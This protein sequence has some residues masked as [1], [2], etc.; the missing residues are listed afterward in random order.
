[1]YIV[2]VITLIISAIVF[3]IKEQKCPEICHLIYTPVC[4]GQTYSNNCSLQVDAC[5]TGQDIKFVDDEP[6]SK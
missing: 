6:C 4:N 5:E 2:H 3:C 1:M